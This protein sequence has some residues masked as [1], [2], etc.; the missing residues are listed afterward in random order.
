MVHGSSVAVKDAPKGTDDRPSIS[1]A[2]DS[3]SEPEED[4][5]ECWDELMNSDH[6]S[7]TDSDLD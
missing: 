2:Q 3:E 5:L 6:D 7:D 4:M 1:Y